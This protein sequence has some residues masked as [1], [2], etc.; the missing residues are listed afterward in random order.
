MSEK[1]DGHNY[2]ETSVLEELAL[3]ERHARDGSAVQA[4]CSCIEEKHL[5]VLSGLASEMPTLTQ[6]KDEAAYYLRFADLM[7]A[8]RQEILNG[9]FKVPGNPA[10][11]AFLPH[12]LTECEKSHP[13]V[14][15]KLSSCIHDAELK[16]CGEH[17]TDYGDC[18]CN[19]VAVCRASVGCP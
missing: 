7:R 17:T 12:G 15:E 4:G 16:C 19:P 10:T 3:S 9:E 8:K 2:T 11:R 18:T 14:R 13:G 6:D 5:L 1:F